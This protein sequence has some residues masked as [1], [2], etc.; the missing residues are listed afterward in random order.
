MWVPAFPLNHSRISGAI[1]LVLSD[2]SVDSE[3]PVVAL[4]ISR[5]VGPLNVTCLD[6]GKFRE[7]INCYK[8]K[9]GKVNTKYEKGF[10]TV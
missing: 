4:S 5:S 7:M 8:D 3:V 10:C 6:K 9:R 1:I 2:I